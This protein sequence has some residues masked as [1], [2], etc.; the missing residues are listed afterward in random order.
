MGFLG[1]LVDAAIEANE[2]AHA[3]RLERGFHDTIRRLQALGDRI[4]G[5]ALVKF[6]KRRGAL[7]AASPNWSV[8]GRIK[9]GRELQAEARKEYD[10]NQTE[11]YSL[12]L[13]GAW[14]EARAR[15]S[16]RAQKVYSQ[17]E[18]LASILSSE[19]KNRSATQIAT[20]TAPIT[21][22]TT[23]NLKDAQRELQ[24][25]YDA[26]VREVE[27]RYPD[28]NPDSPRYDH[29]VTGALM[30][31]KVAYEKSGMDSVTAL[32]RALSDVGRR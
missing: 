10:F 23:L 29:G 3:V 8:E 4:R 13:A 32:R 26:L 11:S 28:L 16:E 12:W 25:A 7:E 15:S 31:R 27:S 19:A 18:E 9:A 2:E 17:I 1:K 5:E 21:P 24:R 20:Q 14:L 6:L 30:A 22:G